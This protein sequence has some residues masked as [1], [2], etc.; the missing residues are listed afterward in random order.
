MRLLKGIAVLFIMLVTFSV[1]YLGVAL[2][3]SSWYPELNM[4]YQPKF[5]DFQKR[6]KD[7]QGKFLQN[8]LEPVK[9][10]LS[11]NECEGILK[12]L[13]RND[14]GFQKI[15]KGVGLKIASGALELKT[16][17]EIYNH[18]VSLGATLKPYYQEGSHNFVLQMEQFKLGKMP[19][20]PR[21][22]LYLLD[23]FNTGRLLVIKRD[24]IG[25]N[26]SGLPFDLAYLKMENR[27]LQA[28][29]ALST[30][31]VTKMV[32]KERSLLQE[33]SRSV[34]GLEQDLSSPQAKEFISILKGKSSLD[35]ADIIKAKQIYDQLPSK[36]KE[37]LKEKAEALLSIPQVR[38]ALLKYG[39]KF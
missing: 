2:A 7:L 26:L 23:K 9:I 13:I 21:L 11:E 25:L 29:F 10:T 36:D 19:I 37:T 28:A 12:S 33:V 38:E 14:A 4:E 6:M 5:S 32:A 17:V 35:P 30:V 34:K 22:V 31:K 27:T 16:N 15:V 24:T 18:Q 1:A 8:P 3:T 20:P 39:Y